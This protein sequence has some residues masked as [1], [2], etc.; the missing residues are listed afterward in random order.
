MPYK[1]P[2]KQR[3]AMREIM[4]RVRKYAD[5][6]RWATEVLSWNEDTYITIKM[7]NG[8]VMSFGA[9]PKKDWKNWLKRA[10]KLGQFPNRIKLLRDLTPEEYAELGLKNVE[11]KAKPSIPKSEKMLTASVARGLD[12]PL[13]KHKKEVK[14]EQ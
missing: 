9:V 3:Q 7:L 1:D 11:R 14:V 4:K 2:S 5:D 12:L 8:K 10:R 13:P 6:G